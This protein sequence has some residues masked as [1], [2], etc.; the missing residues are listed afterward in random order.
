[1]K[2]PFTLPLFV[3]AL[4]F[5]FSAYSVPKLNSLPASQNVIFLDF[6][7]HYVS[8][9]VW[10]SGNPFT[11]APAGIS[12]AYITDIFN[13]TAED[14]R[15]FNVNITTDSAKYLAAPLTQ[16]IRIIVTP[17]S[18]WY[19][20]AVGGVSYTGSF[21]WGDDTPG[22]VFC[23]K[24]PVGG[25]ISPKMVGE[26]C[27]HESGHTLGLSHQSKYDGS[28][29]MLEIYSSGTGTGECG[30]SPVMGNSYYR[31]MTGWNDG[32]TQFG[33]ANT[34]D[35]LSIIVSANGPTFIYRTDDYTETMNAGTTSLTAT[36]FNTNGIITTTTDKDAFRLVLTQNSNFHMDATPFNIGVNDEGANLD[37]KLQLF[38]SGGTLLRTYDPSATM[39][40]VIDTVLNA[41]TY[42]FKVDGSGNANVS[43]YGSLGSYT[44][45][46]TSG[47]LPIRD[48]ALNGT[49]DKGKHNLNWNIIADEPIRTIVVE[50]SADGT[51]FKP[52][53]TVTPAARNFSYQPY[54]NNTLYYRLKVTSVID[55][56]VYSNVVVLRGAGKAE[57]LF[58]VSTLVQN[59]IAVNAGE[60]YQY[61]ISD[62]NGRAVASGNAGKGI[63]KIAIN[64]QPNGLYIISLIS[65]NQIQTERIIKQ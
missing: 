15:P 49:T 53:T 1:M 51:N 42:Y 24:L 16:R 56:T 21:T 50:A 35:N 34:Q 40:V 10:N 45:S 9:S 2:K 5:S 38:N 43:D 65:N 14:F 48:V 11:C 61:K 31:N 20:A 44:L 19:P 30:W 8:S 18:A 17:T 39:N 12:D 3:L 41:G 7:G 46:G 47:A 37:I 54:Q 63:N 6:D 55:Q 27:S 32:P 33:C 4:L 62:A 23:D 64:N 60:N 13:R 25:P 36:G 26:C 57:K 22:F 29:G 58:S 28:C 59:E 52:V